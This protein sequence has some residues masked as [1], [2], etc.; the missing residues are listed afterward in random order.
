MSLRNKTEVLDCILSLHSH[1]QESC[2]LYTIKL[3]L[4]SV[5]SGLPMAHM[6]MNQQLTATP[7]TNLPTE[8][9]EI[10]P[11]AEIQPMGCFQARQQ[12]LP[13]CLSCLPPCRNNLLLGKQ[14]AFGP[15][16]CRLGLWVALGDWEIIN[17]VQENERVLKKRKKESRRGR[18]Q[19]CISR[20]GGSRQE[21][22]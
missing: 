6:Q 12:L 21:S 20:R 2:W 13:R 10:Q 22:F 8:S 5:Y 11:T 15:W 4:A 7:G 19:E 14:W 17:K 3:Y 16:S 18:G 9:P 1:R